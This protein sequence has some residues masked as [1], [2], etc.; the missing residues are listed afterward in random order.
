VVEIPAIEIRPPRILHPLDRALRKLASYDWLILTSVNGVESLATRMKR[1]SIPTKQLRGIRIAA[2]GPATRKALEDRSVRVD[3]MPREYVAEAVVK[4]LRRRVRGQRVLLVRA[5]IARDVLPRQ[6]RQ[7]GARVEVV[8]AYKTVVPRGSAARVRALLKDPRRR[9]DFITFTSSS[10][11]RNFA[12]MVRGSRLDGIRLAS[13][14]PVTSATLRAVGLR[15]DV[16][17]KTYTVDGLV[18][19]MARSV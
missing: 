2:I 11:A 8:P 18:K 17:A 14:G 10:T 16:A 4:A 12:A 3:V 1:L 15:V 9:P 7:A 13:I 19:A 5:A 6:L